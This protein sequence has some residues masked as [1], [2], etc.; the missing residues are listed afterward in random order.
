MRKVY[1]QKKDDSFVDKNCYL[2]WDGFRLRGYET[3]FYTR[4]DL[5]KGLL[6]LTKD[7]IVCG[8]IGIVQMALTQL[9]ASHP[10]NID[11]PDEIQ[12]A[13]NR[14]IWKTTLGEV[15]QS[16]FNIHYSPIFIKP[17]KFQ[18]YFTGHVV[19]EFK[20][21]IKTSALDDDFEVLAQEVIK[22]DSEWRFYVL[23]NEIVGCGHYFGDCLTFPDRTIVNKILGDFTSKPVAC[24][25]D[26]G[27]ASGKTVLVEVNDGYALGNYGLN[28]S[29]YSQ[30]MEAR[31][32]E[33]VS[34]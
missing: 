31:W 18:K 3:L 13:A 17:L 20:D 28:S 4:D 26:V 33:M 6:P 14:K 7:S 30:M 21:L 8:H 19:R 24:S 10:K 15:R 11:L 12:W 29:F 9:G 23:K 2:A 22:F 5:A 34:L 1:I 32:D 25:I 27:V 16:V